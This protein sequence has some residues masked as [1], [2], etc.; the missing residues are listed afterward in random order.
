MDL[1]RRSQKKMIKL[2]EKYLYQSIQQE[3]SITFDF[4]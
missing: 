1:T 4:F 2:F 3:N